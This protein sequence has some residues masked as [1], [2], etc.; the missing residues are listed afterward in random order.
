MKQNS[1]IELTAKRITSSSQSSQLEVFLKMKQ[2]NNPDFSFLYP[3][4]ALHQYYL[5]V[6]EK[7]TKAEERCLESEKSGN[8]EAVGDNSKSPGSERSE[9]NAGIAGLLGCYSSSSDE[10][11]SETPNQSLNV[12]D[13]SSK[14]KVSVMH[15]NDKESNISCEENSNVYET[16]AQ[17][18]KSDRLARLRRWKETRLELQEK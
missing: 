14:M 17:K 7:I 15:G 8:D 13:E 11:K 18:K 10:D 4:N 5:H 6:K 1:I 12:V 9:K 16:D 2:K 3:S